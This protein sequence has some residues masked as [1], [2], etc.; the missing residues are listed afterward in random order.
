[1]MHLLEKL[2]ALGIATGLRVTDAIRGDARPAA[3][4]DRR[5]SRARG[6]SGAYGE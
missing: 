2:V 6:E 3:I 1:M 5:C 4:L